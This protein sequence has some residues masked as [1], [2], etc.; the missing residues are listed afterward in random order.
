MDAGDISWYNRTEKGFWRAFSRTW[1]KIIFS[2]HDFFAGIY[3]EKSLKEPL[4]FAIICGIL[5]TVVSGLMGF[6]ANNFVVHFAPKAGEIFTSARLLAMYLLLVVISPLAVTILVFVG[7]AILHIFVLIFGGKEGFKATF[8]VVAYSNA[9]SL[10]GIVPVIGT[11]FGLLYKTVL[12]IL[13][14]KYINR[15]STLKAVMVVILPSLLF[16]VLGFFFIVVG[17]KKFTLPLF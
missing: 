1:A 7:A 9:T 3:T 17:Y 11:I 2:P 10:F 8:K 15:I 6:L 4:L 12:I 16:S 5:L 14:L 13:G